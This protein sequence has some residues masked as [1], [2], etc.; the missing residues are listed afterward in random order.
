MTGN[1]RLKD[2]LS[3][4]TSMLLEVG[5][6]MDGGEFFLSELNGKK[7]EFINR[8]GAHY[9][10]PEMY[11][12]HLPEFPTD[13]LYIFNSAVQALSFMVIRQL[14]DIHFIA[15]GSAPG[16]SV[17][18]KLQEVIPGKKIVLGFPSTL[19][20]KINET[21]LAYELFDNPL[22]IA[23]DGQY[24][25]VRLGKEVRRIYSD[26]FSLSRVMKSFNM[27]IEHVRTVKPPKGNSTF[28]ELLEKRNDEE[29]HTVIK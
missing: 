6:K 27:L 29:K 20:G 13:K 16:Q 12:Q 19:M 21:L 8:L 28:Y 9:V 15:V 25:S 11:W 3:L 22:K 14:K 5:F 10:P 17:I 24:V 23:L 4:P 1:I 26:T 2:S 7:G 18:T